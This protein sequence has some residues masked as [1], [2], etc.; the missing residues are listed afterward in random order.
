MSDIVE[1]MNKNIGGLI[2]VVAGLSVLFAIL[3]NSKALLIIAVVA[4]IGVA[5]YNF[6]KK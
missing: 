3:F 6:T 4:S 2:S 1:A 5:V